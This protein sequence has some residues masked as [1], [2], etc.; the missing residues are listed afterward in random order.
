MKGGGIFQRRQR[1]L[2]REQKKP[3]ILLLHIISI[4]AVI[5]E[6]LLAGKYTGLFR[7][8]WNWRWNA[9][10][11]FGLGHVFIDI[12]LLTFFSN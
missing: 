4:A 1:K 8:D 11:F 7:L 12:I 6:P 2:T 10:S 3:L 9:L 5:E